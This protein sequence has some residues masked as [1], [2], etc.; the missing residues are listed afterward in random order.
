MNIQFKRHHDES[1]PVRS[2]PVRAAHEMSIFPLDA[3]N[4]S[5]RLT[6]RSHS[7]RSRDLIKSVRQCKT[8]AAEREVIAKEAAALRKAFKEQDGHYRHRNVAKVRMH[9]GATR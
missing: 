9:G 8:A 1:S 7:P 5:A 6:R 3:I 4:Q 2:H